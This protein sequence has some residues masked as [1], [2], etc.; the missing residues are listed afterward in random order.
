ML[1]SGTTSGAAALTSYLAADSAAS[2]AANAYHPTLAPI[3]IA[4]TIVSAIAITSTRIL[5]TMP[6]QVSFWTAGGANTTNLNKD[7]CDTILQVTS[8][9]GATT[10]AL[11][12]TDACVAVS[13]TT[14]Y[15]NLASDYS[16]TDVINFKSTH[17]AASSASLRAGTR[18]TG[19]AAAPA[20]GFG[21]TIR[22]TILSA[23]ATS[24]T[25]VTVVLPYS[26]IMYNTGGNT[27]SATLSAANCAAILTL[28]GPTSPSIAAPGCVMTDTSGQTTIAVTIDAWAD[29]MTINI[30]AAHA[31]AA[32]SYSLRRSGTATTASWYI[33]SPTAL[34][35][36]PTFQ[37]ATLVSPTQ[38]A[39][40]LFSTTNRLLN[41][42]TP[43]VAQTGLSG[44]DC[45]KILEIKSF[46]GAAGRDLL[47]NASACTM[48]GTTSTQA[49]VTVNLAS[50]TYASG[51]TIN[52]VSGHPIAGSPALYTGDSTTANIPYTR[53]P[54]GVTIRPAV[55]SAV[56]I[57][58]TQ[59]IIS[60]P[61]TSVIYDGSS[62]PA[63][64]TTL[65]GT[66]SPTTQLCTDVLAVTPTGSSTAKTLASST[67]ACVVSDASAGFTTVNVTLDSA[68]AFTAGDK[69]NIIATHGDNAAK[70]SLRAKGSNITL[71]AKYVALA[72]A[73]MIDPALG[74]AVAT[75]ANTIEVT[76]PS[77][78]SLWTAANSRASVGGTNDR[79]SGAACTDVLAVTSASGAAKNLSVV[80]SPTDYTCSSSTT[81]QF[82]TN[83]YACSITSSGSPAV[84]KLT[85]TL[86]GTGG[87]V[88]AAG[89]FI[90]VKAYA[91]GKPAMRVG[92][93]NGG[94]NRVYVPRRVMIAPKWIVSARA[95]STK[96]IH[97]KLPVAGF[98]GTNPLNA[99][100]CAI[101]VAV[102]PTG[103]ATA[104]ALDTTSACRVDAADP[105]L[106]VVTL[107]GTDVV[108]V[109]D[110]VAILGTNTALKA[111]NADGALF[112][113]S[114]ATVSHSLAS[115]T[116]V[117]ADTIWAVFSTSAVLATSASAGG[118]TTAVCDS[119]FQFFD[120]S[121]TAK[122]V[123]PISSCSI[124]SGMPT[125][126]QIKLNS[127]TSY[128]TGDKI[129]VKS[130][131]VLLGPSATVA[132]QPRA[133][134]LTIAPALFGASAM[135]TSPNAVTLRLPATS[136][137]AE[138]ATAAQCNAAVVFTSVAGVTRTSPI[139]SCALAS[140][141]TTVSIAMVPSYQ[142][143]NGETLNAGA[144]NA[145]LTYGSATGPA[146][147]PNPTAVPVFSTLS[148]AV[149]ESYT[150]LRVRLP[151]AS[152]VPAN[153]SA[154]DCANAL[155]LTSASGTVKNVTFASCALSANRDSL[156]V[157][158]PSNSTYAA[159]DKLD[160]KAGQGELRVQDLG[161]G[162]SYVARAVTVTPTFFAAPA[163]LT[164][165]TTV[166]ATLPYA[167]A[168]GSGSCSAALTLISAAGA[169]K[170]N[171]V[172]SCSLGA[173]KVTLTVTLAASVYA[174]GDVLNVI[175]GQTVLTLDGSSVAYTPSLTAPVITPTFV[176][177]A[178]TNATIISVTLPT[179]AVLTGTAAADCNAA[180]VI[181]SNGSAVASPL[182][183][184][185]V[186]TDGLTLTLTAAA[187]Y[188]P[189]AGDTINVA[190]SQTV[191]RAGSATGPAYVPRAT[192]VL[193]TVP[194][195]PPSPPP[196]PAPSPPPSPPL[197]TAN[198][199][200]R[201]LATGPLSC[202]VLIGTDT[203]TTTSGNFTGLPSY[204]GKKA[205]FRVSCKDAV[206]GAIYTDDTVASTLPA[207]LTGLILS[208]VTA[209]ASAS[210]SDIKSV[211]DLANTNK[212]YL[213]L[214][215][216]PVNA[217]AYGSATNLLAYD[218]YVKGYVALET[219]AVAV[220]NVEGMVAANLLMYTKF[221]DGLNAS[222]AGRDISAAEALAA[223]QYV[224][225][226]GLKMATAPLNTSSP[227]AILDLL[228][229]TYSILTDKNTTAGGRRLMQGSAVSFTQLQAQAAALA[230]AAAD[231]N[232]LVTVQQQ[233]LIAAINAGTSISAA[234]LT[235]I[236]TEASKVVVTQ[237]TVIASAATGLGSGAISPASFTSSYT[238]S[239]LTT[240][241]AQQQLAA[242][243][244]TDV[245]DTP[246][247][248][249]D[250]DDKKSNT[251]LIVGLV[252]GL[253]GG[254][255]VI[256]LIVVFI[257]MR[258]RKQN[259]AAAGQAAA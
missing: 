35:V 118:L 173:D 6:F 122:T 16:D 181:T 240:L 211:A 198:Y 86:D 214:L 243:P 120:A 134:A 158:L 245:T 259:V 87:N 177:A 127:S 257:V 168:V 138:G 101:V 152:S 194:S 78:S 116:L 58:A 253:V 14:F 228:N 97:V 251:G 80:V 43:P 226:M 5:V 258:R 100:A 110:S 7:D 155:V 70:A 224:M 28:S 47:A 223:A 241:V 4:P 11:K 236:I 200:A 123:S 22:P 81:C 45:G 60:L 225:A 105:T 126:V 2:S 109:A 164:A 207:G 238:G 157:T 71:S 46:D 145:V 235:N 239:A 107:G 55:L 254:A 89:D 217:S 163:V 62:T 192:A 17:P 61:T 49:T 44:T 102:T 76:L 93:S 48:P 52:V 73:I 136:G 197:S 202:N 90:D 186:S 132:F 112:Q 215:G 40:S 189:M 180:V 191:L 210:V 139:A 9:D 151:T 29:S 162:S 104:K 24:T 57:S 25:S 209:L 113:A 50:A 187:T 21:V 65:S 10:R 169:P 129:N 98:L 135:L 77:E 196:S 231:S 106:L 242:P 213:R 15:V 124:P 119:V 184:C 256:T 79:L 174:A 1:P 94:D 233:K 108:E 96:I 3:P 37:S 250:S 149:L 32:A 84:Y 150:A 172:A 183:A 147:I 175:P 220:L 75:S 199:S 8:T 53:L 92:S 222:V 178:L 66:G 39:L 26:S 176:S 27:A 33:S 20:A 143:G 218:Y 255:I 141:S 91:A 133:A 125:Y 59:V 74:T 56:A 234:D 159:G 227:S 31:P 38:V 190:A 103:S 160:V 114:S 170:N 72:T 42:A 195:P 130:S 69:V 85:V 248:P 63:V 111:T 182:S 171:S 203:V 216:V 41:A 205:S 153:F 193:V 99:T 54:T 212:D 68:A 221:F 88:F 247:P 208:P 18:L 237:S 201:G 229:A 34:K 249:S 166:V 219:P 67:S 19:T 142:Y 148:E 128:V 188:K 137:L 83:A 179:A 232:A 165:A 51:D 131:G 167:S 252:V 144:S 117:A 244:G 23:Y 12:A 115:A 230:A 206:T 95:V 30:N 121:G 246:S 161:V 36:N 140:D 146:Y 64:V 185:A 154:T 13:G 82:T 204:A 156:L